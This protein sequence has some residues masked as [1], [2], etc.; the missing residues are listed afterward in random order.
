M[1]AK[2]VSLELIG[3]GITRV[4][5]FITSILNLGPNSSSSQTNLQTSKLYEIIAMA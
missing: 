1:E 5:S 4:P 3:S 2:Q